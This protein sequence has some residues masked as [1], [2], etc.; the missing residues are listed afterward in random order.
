MITQSIA[1]CIGLTVLMFASPALSLDRGTPEQ[2]QA[3]TPDAM[4][5]CGPFIP[6]AVQ[7]RA[8][9]LSRRAS[10]SPACRAAI[11]PRAHAPRKRRHT[12]R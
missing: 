7:V 6:D 2:Q 5:F 8:C 1:T 9:L 4:S 10:L 3:C 11:A 12:H